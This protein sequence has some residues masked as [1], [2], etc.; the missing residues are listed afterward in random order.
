MTPVFLA[1]ANLWLLTRLVCLFRN[2]PAKGRTWLA[3]TAVELAALAVLYPCNG[4]WLGIAASLLAL[5]LLGYR[6]EQGTAR[7]DFSR[8]LLGVAGLAVW[9]V[10]F[11]PRLGLGFRPELATWTERLAQWTAL[12]PLQKVLGGVRVQLVL[13]GLLLSANEANL[14]IRTVFDWLELKPRSLPAGGG[15][16]DEGEFNRGR[17]IGMLERVLLYGF[18]LQA[19]YGAIGFVLAAK[20][21]TRSKALDDRPF[22]EYVLIGTLLSACLALLTGGAVKWLLQARG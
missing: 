16:V 13:F 7:K 6:L 21:F 9:S 10:W 11:S 5:N 15:A 19:Q 1:F 18:V 14:V 20:A 8:L 3:K 4:V 12:A 17:V 22:A 2:E